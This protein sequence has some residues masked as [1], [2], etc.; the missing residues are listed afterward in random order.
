MDG[1][2]SNSASM[3]SGGGRLVAQEVSWVSSTLSEDLLSTRP[4]PGCRNLKMG[5]LWKLAGVGF[6]YMGLFCTWD[7]RFP[8]RIPCP[9]SCHPGEWTIKVLWSEGGHEAQA[10]T[11]GEFSLEMSNI[12]NKNDGSSPQNIFFLQHFP[13][14]E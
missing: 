1:E 8:L 12:R 10:Q 4:I 5:N 6:Q 3:F 14:S 11:S 2:R 13:T 9:L 7:L